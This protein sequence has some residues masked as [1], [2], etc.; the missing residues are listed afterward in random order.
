MRKTTAPTEWS[1]V[2]RMVSI[3][4]ITPHPRNPRTHPDEQMRQLKASHERFSQYRSV[5]LWE[6][7]G[8]GYVQVAGHGIVEAMKQ[9]GEHEVRADILPASTSQETIDG[10]LVADNNIALNAEDDDQLLVALLQEQA[11]AGYDL[12]SLGTDE[13]ALRQILEALGDEYV[14]SGGEGEGDGEE[15]EIPEEVETRAKVGDIWQLGRHRIACINSLDIS[16]VKRLFTD[17]IPH[18]IWADPPYG[19]D[20]VATNGYVGGGEAYDIPFGGVKHRKGDVGGTAAHMRKTGKSYLAEQQQGLRGSD[21]ASKPFGSKAVRGSDGATN[22]VEVGKYFPVIGDDSTATAIAAYNLC[23]QYWST[24]VQ[25][26]W[27]ANYY[28]YALPPSP[29][30]IV[31]DKEN[32]GNFADAELAWCSDKSAVRIFKHMWNGMLKDSEHGQRRV[33]PTQKPCALFCWCAEKY[34]KPGD[35]IFD[36]FLGSGISIIGAEMLNDNRVVY[37]CELSPEYCDVVI[38]R[39]EKHTGQT[40]TLL[41][42]IEEVARG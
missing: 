29:C 5:V 25:I 9:R 1:I 10:I 14:G 7:P 21:G 35:V 38:A 41:E 17:A 23:S 36:P 13:E 42:H 15:D 30:W 22:V 26:W 20:I 12:A 37:G 16:Q 27:G 19:L 8:G 3:D 6:R 39:W 11:D 2:N 33:H 28:A 4:R 31:W 24:A 34:G 40:A 18:M 32:T